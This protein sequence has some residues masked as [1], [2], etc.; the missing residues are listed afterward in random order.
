MSVN[1]NIN[2][3]NTSYDSPIIVGK[4]NSVKIQNSKTEKHIKCT[5]RSLKKIGNKNIS[6]F[7]SY[8]WNDTN[9][10][11]D[12]DDKLQRC[13]YK[14]ERDIRDA[15]Y[16]QSIKKFMKRIRKTDYSLIVL[17]DS[18]LKSENCMC[19]IFEF[20]KDDNYK[21]RIIPVILESANDIWGLSKGIQYT[22]YWKNREKEFKDLLKE[23][24]EES[25]AG[26]INELR[27]ISSIK[28]SIGEVIAIFR[29]MKMF[30]GSDKNLVKNIEV[31]L[32]KECFYK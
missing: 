21:D 24:D 1:I 5:R 25:K 6:I 20:I 7:I 19:E 29:N 28:D 14:I 31:Y 3:K 12:F 23:I 18:F 8:S 22:I 26:Y 11:D 32:K 10:V 15:E 30:D 2:G 4:N 13:G 17:S 9:F 27:N 16:A